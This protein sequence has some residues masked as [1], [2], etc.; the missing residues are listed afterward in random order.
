M[1]SAIS[2]END[3]QVSLSTPKKYNLFKLYL[4][5]LSQCYVGVIA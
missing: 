1:T 4:E 5:F 2:A 3:F